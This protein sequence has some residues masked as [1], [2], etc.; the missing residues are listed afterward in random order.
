M[1]FRRGEA[2]SYP[3]PRRQAAVVF[4]GRMML[5]ALGA[6]SARQTVF[7]SLPTTTRPA[8]VHMAVGQ[9]RALA[10]AYNASEAPPQT[11]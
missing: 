3:S 8:G 4:G 10:V 6:D 1:H 9:F 7:S 11:N 5:H 2:G